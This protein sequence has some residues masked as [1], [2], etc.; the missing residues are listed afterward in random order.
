MSTRNGCFKKKRKKVRELN[1]AKYGTLTCEYCFNNKLTT[2]PN[3]PN[4]AT[5]DHIQAVSNG[6]GNEWENL[7]IAC[8]KCNHKKN[9]NVDLKRN[10]FSSFDELRSFLNGIQG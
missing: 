2:T 9:H 7:T 5:I 3:K 6:G 10:D 4:C 8:L 1:I